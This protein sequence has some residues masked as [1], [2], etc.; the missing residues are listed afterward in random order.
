VETR[1][2][3]VEEVCRAF[4]VFPIMVGHS[5]KAATFAS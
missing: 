5:D 2:L 4:G 3:Q 1:R